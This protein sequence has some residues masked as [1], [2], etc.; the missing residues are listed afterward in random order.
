MFSLLVWREEACGKSFWIIS[1]IVLE[2]FL[3]E[4][5]SEVMYRGLS[6]SLWEVICVYEYVFVCVRVHKHISVGAHMVECCMYLRSCLCVCLCINVG[7]CTWD[8]V[9]FY[10]HDCAY[11]WVC[12]YMGMHEYMCVYICMWRYVCMWLYTPVF[13]VCMSMCICAINP[14]ST[15][16]KLFSIIIFIIWE[17]FVSFQEYLFM[18]II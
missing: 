14:T 5:M 12:A 2:F 3:V 10:V 11:V 4:F 17:Q 16:Y 9:C 13:Y 18:L 6:F 7:M 15:C 1:I 8:C